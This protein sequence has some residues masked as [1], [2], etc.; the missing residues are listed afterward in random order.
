MEP[1]TIFSAS[2]GLVSICRLTFVAVD[3][4]GKGLYSK[5]SK[6]VKRDDW[7]CFFKTSDLLAGKKSQHTSMPGELLKQRRRLQQRPR[8][9]AERNLY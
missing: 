3:F 4:F 6:P 5:G 2:V 1:I 9:R 8:L 7:Y